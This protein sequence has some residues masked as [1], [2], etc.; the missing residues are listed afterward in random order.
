MDSVHQSR[1][2][3]SLEKHPQPVTQNKDLLTQTEIRSHVH[4]RDER[5]SER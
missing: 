1:L 2:I 4:N 3:M 5:T